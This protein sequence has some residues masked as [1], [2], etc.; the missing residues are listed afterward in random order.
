MQYSDLCARYERV[1][2]YTYICVCSFLVVFCCYLLLALP[3]LNSS[4]QREMSLRLY[5]IFTF[6]LWI[7]CYKLIRNSA[8][9]CDHVYVNARVCLCANAYSRYMMFL[10][11]QLNMQLS[12][13]NIY[14]TL[15][16]CKSR[17]RYG[18]RIHTEKSNIHNIS[19]KGNWNN[20]SKRKKKWNESNGGG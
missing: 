17:I 10:T 5:L 2:I 6:I 16:V 9:K 14:L 18:S 3:F 1:Y 20:N 19:G 12:E 13:A 11:Y 8:N 15:Y 4:S 7:I